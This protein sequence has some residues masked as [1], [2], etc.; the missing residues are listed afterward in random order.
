MSEAEQC[1]R[2]GRRIG[3]AET[4]HLHADRVVCRSC[5]ELLREGERPLAY[6]RPRPPASEIRGPAYAT[7]AAAASVVVAAGVA[8]AVGAI[9]WLGTILM[10]PGELRMGPAGVAAALVLAGIVV[11]GFGEGLKCLREIAINTR[12]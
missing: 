3:A 8:E 12:P 1:S 5:W 6:A 11:A 9:V 7:L 4:P 10:A 2:C